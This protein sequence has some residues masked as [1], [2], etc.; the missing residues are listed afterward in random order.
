LKEKPRRHF[1]YLKKFLE[2]HLQGNMPRLDVNPYD[3]RIPTGE[4][5]SRVVQNLLVGKYPSDHIIALTDVYTGSQPPEFLDATDAK[6]KMRQW[7]GEGP[8]FHPHVAHHDFEEWLLPYWTSIQRLA[9]H[10][11]KAPT[12]KPEAVNHGN[13]PAYRIKEIFEIGTCRDSYIKPRD[14]GRILSNNDLSVAVSEC[15]ELKSFV[16]TI[17]SVCGGEII[18]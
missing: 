11:K 8:R 12:G 14:A 15:P 2:S 7:V 6:N 18:P 4:K 9:G 16:N 13:P 10:N 5:L 17:I 3:G 1:P